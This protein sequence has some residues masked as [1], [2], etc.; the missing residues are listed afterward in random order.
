MNSER[1]N[2]NTNAEMKMS[3][4]E[5]NQTTKSSSQ[6]TLNGSEGIQLVGDPFWNTPVNFKI[7]TFDEFMGCEMKFFQDH[8][9]WW[10]EDMGNRYG[11][12]L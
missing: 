1:N 6:I 8:L 5:Q 3:K 11:N 9:L 4:S 2:D 7:T 12:K 10:A